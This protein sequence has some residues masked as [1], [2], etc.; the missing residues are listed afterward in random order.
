MGR[1]GEG[2]YD[3]KRITKRPTYKRDRISVNR[4]LS[5]EL[6]DLFACYRGS[7]YVP[8]EVATN[9]IGLQFSHR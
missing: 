6:L 2:I 7:P 4:D 9:S 3:L 1:S 8:K 5:R